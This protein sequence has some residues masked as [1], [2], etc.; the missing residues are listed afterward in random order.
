[1]ATIEKRGAYWRAKIRRKGYP[2]QTHSFDT[3]A[4]AEKWARDIERDMDRS[5]FV[6]R[7]ETEKNTLGDLIDRYLREVTPTKRSAESEALRLKALKRGPLGQI[8]M[9]ALSSGHVAAF[10]DSRLREVSPASVNKEL[11]HISHVIETARREWN[12]QLSEN[13]VRFVRRPKNARGRDRRLLGDEEARLMEACNDARNPYLARIV[14]LALETA[15][16]QSE[17]VSLSWKHV[18]LNKRVAYLPMTKNGEARSIPLSTAAAEVLRSL[19]RS[20]NGAVFPGVTAEA[21]KRAFI[22]ATQRARIENLRF[23]DLRHEATSRLF[24]KGLNPMEAASV[25][26]HK[27]LQMLKR[28]THLRAEDLARKLG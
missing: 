26:G 6:D 14:R 4:S 10:R 16:R 18:D 21:V 9:S 23:H 2:E 28:Y 1:M 24:E 22:R 17:I 13:P 12:I 25:T 20:I 15:M 19:P 7:S 11:N 27:T 8:K 3:K 5:L